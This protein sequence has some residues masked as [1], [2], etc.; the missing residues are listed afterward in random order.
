[1]LVG[2]T[3]TTPPGFAGR[4]V[5]RTSQ[6]IGGGRRRRSIRASGTASKIIYEAQLRQNALLSAK[7]APRLCFGAEGMQTV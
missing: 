1:M 6:D 5:Q 7:R 2:S 3:S 4:Q